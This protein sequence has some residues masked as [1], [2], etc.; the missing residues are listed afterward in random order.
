MPPS[1]SVFGAAGFTGAL[2]ARLLQRHPSFELKALTARSDQGRRL[3]DLY[4]HLAPLLATPCELAVYE[5]SLRPATNCD[6]PSDWAT[7]S[8]RRR[9]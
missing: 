1:V 2:T 7:P 4:P 3:D 8:F 6:P 5:K 9:K